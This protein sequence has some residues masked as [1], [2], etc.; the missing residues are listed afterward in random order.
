MESAIALQSLVSMRESKPILG[1]IIFEGSSIARGYGDE[2]QRFGYA[3]RLSHYYQDY[4]MALP[5]VIGRCRAALC[6]PICTGSQTGHLYH[7]RR[8]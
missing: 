1:H 2:T 8:M 6:T 5:A 4:S 3:G 7:T